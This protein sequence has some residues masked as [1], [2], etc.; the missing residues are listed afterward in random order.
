[1]N[2]LTFVSACV[3]YPQVLFTSSGPKQYPYKQHINMLNASFFEVSFYCKNCSQW[4][5]LT[6]NI[7]RN[8][9]SEQRRSERKGMFF[10]IYSSGNLPKLV[11]TVTMHWSSVSECSTVGVKSRFK[12]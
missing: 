2:P 7:P 6:H 1:V 10:G 5:V 3:A 8:V 12:L 4:L 11:I 9:G